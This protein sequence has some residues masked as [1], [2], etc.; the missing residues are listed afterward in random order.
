[1]AIAREANAVSHV[2][3]KVQVGLWVHTVILK[4][5]TA[6]LW[7]ASPIPRICILGRHDR[8]NTATCFVC[9]C[10]CVR[11]CVRV[12]GMSTKVYQMNRT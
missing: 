10:V 12:C 11:A 2:M 4:A 6:L 5:C 3:V 7:G 9:V 1:M 8:E